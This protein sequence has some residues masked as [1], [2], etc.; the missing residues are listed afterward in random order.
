[1]CDIFFANY[2]SLI[3]F[4]PMEYAARENENTFLI[5]NWRWEYAL[6]FLEEENKLKQND[7]VMIRI[8]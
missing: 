1:M 5:N 6:S 7:A 3:K 2:I 4:L 8:K